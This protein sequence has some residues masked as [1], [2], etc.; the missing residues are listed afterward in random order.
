VLVIDPPGEV[1]AFDPCLWLDPDGMLWLFWAQS[2]GRW[3]GRGGVWCITSEE[4]RVRAPIWSKPKRLCDGVMLSKPA[5]LK[6]D[7]QLLPV[8]VWNVPVLSSRPARRMQSLVKQAG[9]NVF[10]LELQ[11]EAPPSMI[12]QVLAPKREYDEH[13]IIE[14]ADKSLWML[15]RTPDG[16]FE[17]TSSD[18]GKNWDTPARSPIP[19]INSRFCIRRLQS[20]RLLLITHEPPDGKTRSHLIARLSE[21]DGKTW[22]GGLL[23]DDRPGVSYPD[24]TEGPKGTIHVI[25]DFER[26]RSKQILSATITESHILMGNPGRNGRLRV[27][28]NQASGAS[29]ADEDSER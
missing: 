18:G 7:A 2:H 17:S 4:S 21:D 13:H 3:D 16:L 28:V 10:A 24:A 23:L 8:S 19:H 6:N 5:V 9:A 12:G 14:R 26:T 29:P 11:F 1:R 15:L 25:Y 20:G 27:L 22:Q